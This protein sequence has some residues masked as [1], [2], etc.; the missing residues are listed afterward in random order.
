MTEDE[1]YDEDEGEEQLVSIG[2]MLS[3]RQAEDLETISRQVAED[4]V[5]RKVR[6]PPQTATIERAII[7]GMMR[8]GVATVVEATSTT[9]LA[10]HDFSQPSHQVLFS[11]CV[12]LASQGQPVDAVSVLAALDEDSLAIVGGTLAIQALS[13]AVVSAAPVVDYARHLVQITERRQVLTTAATIAAAAYSKRPLVDVLSAAQA[14][15]DKVKRELPTA[16]GPF[17]ELLAETRREWQMRLVHTARRWAAPA[18]KSMAQLIVENPPPVPWMIQG[19]IREDSVFFI[20][21]APK[22][23]KTWDAGEIAMSLASGTRAFG[24]FQSYSQGYVLGF[25]LEDDE[26]D[27]RNRYRALAS[28]SA[29]RQQALERIVIEARGSLDL[30]SD[31]D[32][33]GIIATARS[34]PEAPVA[35][36]IDP[37]RDANSGEENSNDDMRRVMQRVRMIRDMLHTTVILNHHMS[38]PSAG[39][40]G[41]AP[42]AAVSLFDRFRGAS[43][44][45]GAWDGALAKESVQ[46]APGSIWARYEVETRGGRNAGAFGLKLQLTDDADGNATAAEYDFYRD[47]QVLIEEA[48]GQK[49]GN[50]KEE[51]V[52]K[53]VVV[54]KAIRA[55]HYQHATEEHELPTFSGAEIA[56]VCRLPDRTVAR[57]LQVLQEE[58][59]IVPQGRKWRYSI[60]QPPTED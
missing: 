53:K 31:D 27:L 33:C 50:P 36:M 21:G 16:P 9:G 13:S 35:I 11:T 10:A 37:F 56:A 47:P 20:G 17:G 46:K 30:L 57:L 6:Y 60:A 4:V 55:L 54:L 49:E 2:S 29:D 59:R 42:I 38:K 7:G 45:R 26:R 1:I 51:P 25:C 41:K 3:A 5:A 14:S 19:L 23:G 43:A 52:D 15:L 34:L 22:E 8:G 28:H 39:A 24:E 44:I 32:C 58:R 18:G 12:A 40:N 48:K